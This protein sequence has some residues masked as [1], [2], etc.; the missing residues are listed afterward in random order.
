MIKDDIDDIL[1]E[2]IDQNWYIS[3][4]QITQKFTNKE[5]NKIWIKRKNNDSN[6]LFPKDAFFK[7][8]DIENVINKINDI[9]ELERYIV[10]IWDPYYDSPYEKNKITGI[11]RDVIN[12]SDY[13]NKDILG[14]LIQY[15]F[16]KDKKEYIKKYQ[17]FYK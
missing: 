5:I 17:N 15:N 7:I 3:H 12:L 9:V 13:E 6:S 4:T 1:L 14:L 11:H 16:K 10:V 2:L 8:S